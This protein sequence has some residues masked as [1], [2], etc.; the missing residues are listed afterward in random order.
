MRFYACFESTERWCVIRKKSQNNKVDKKAML[1]QCTGRRLGPPY[2]TKTA[3]VIYKYSEE[4]KIIWKYSIHNLKKAGLI[5][6]L[7]ERL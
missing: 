2:G 6:S 1:Y 5:E 7:R 4:K 3:V